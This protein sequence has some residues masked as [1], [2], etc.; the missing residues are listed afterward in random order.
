MKFYTGNSFPAKYKNQILVARHGSWNKTNKVGGDVVLVN[1]KKDG[2]AGPMEPFL[3][4]FL[5]NNTYVG[6][7]VDVLV[8]KDGSVLVSDDW[9]GAV[10]R[11]SAGN[12]RTASR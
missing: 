5:D 1:I 7:P 10:W 11:V 6:R 9:N 12:G 2:S 3:T 8:M 4:G